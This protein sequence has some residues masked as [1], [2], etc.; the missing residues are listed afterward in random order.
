MKK[1]KKYLS[2]VHDP[3]GACAESFCA[4]KAIIIIVIYFY[5][6]LESM[7]DEGVNHYTESYGK[8]E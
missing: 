6:G 1:G 7:S 3:M 2:S 5:P 8:A 4:L